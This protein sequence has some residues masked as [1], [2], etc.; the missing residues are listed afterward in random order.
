MATCEEIHKILKNPE[1][2][3][4][5]NEFKD[6]RILKSNDGEKKLCC[7]IVAFANRYGGKILIGINDDDGFEGKGIF[8]DKGIDSYKG[9]IDNII[10]AHIS[11]IIE[12]E[13]EFLECDKHQ[14]K[15]K[16]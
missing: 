10:H 13:I 9:T 3:N 4:M 1:K 11:P 7:E 14:F 6:S 16:E 15:S 2:E 8:K 12:C 5:K